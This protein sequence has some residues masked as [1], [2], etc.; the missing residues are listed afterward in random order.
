M[1]KILMGAAA[2]LFA[3]VLA[4]C[5]Q[6][7]QYTLSEQEVN[8][9]LQKHNDYQKQIGVPGLLDANIVLTQLQSQI[10]RSEPGKVTLSGDAKVNITSIL[11]ADRGSEADAEGAAGLRPGAGRHFPEGHGADRLQ[12]A[13]G[14]N[15][16]GNESADA[17][18]EPVAEILLRPKAGLCAES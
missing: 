9:Y 3:G 18:S 7:T 10:G 16:D 14:K 5:N 6:L 11:D 1:K 4:G 15:A 17:V 13:A 12:R 2:L 8:D